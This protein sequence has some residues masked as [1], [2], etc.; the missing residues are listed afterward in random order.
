MAVDVLDHDDRVVDDQA[1]R[2]HQRQQR[3]QIDREAERQH[4]REGADQRQ[5]NRDDGISTERGEPR[6]SED[7]QRD[8]HQRLDQRDSTS[9]IELFTKSVES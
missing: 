4:H 3:Q 5:R 2:Q 6:N 1:D 7:H 9:W 8:D